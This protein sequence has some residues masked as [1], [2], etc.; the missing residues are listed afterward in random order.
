M[1]LKKAKMAATDKDGLLAQLL[2]DK[3][4][5]SAAEIQGALEE[6]L[7][8]GEGLL[9]ALVR[10]GLITYK[11]LS[12]LI[13]E[14]REALKPKH[15]STAADKASEEDSARATA[16]LDR[17]FDEKKISDERLGE[18]LSE[19]GRLSPDDLHRAKQEQAS[20]GHPLWRTLVNMRLISPQDL[21]TIMKSRFEGGLIYSQDKI[22]EKFLRE[23]GLI[24]EEELGRLLRDKGRWGKSLVRLALEKGLAKKP[25]LARALEENLKAQF[26]KLSPEIIDRS[27]LGLLP[28]SFVREQKVIPLS[29]EDKELRLAMVNP[30]NLSLIDSIGLMTGHKIR[31]LVALEDEI[32]SCIDSIFGFKKGWG[33]K[34]RTEA[35]EEKSAPLAPAAVFEITDIT[36]VVQIVNS[37]IE[38]AVNARATD[39]HIEPQ[40]PDM[41]VRYRIDGML[42]DIMTIPKPLQLPTISRVKILAEMDITERRMPQDGHFSHVVG[43]KEFNMR[44]ATMPTKV[45][46]KVVI[47]LLTESSVLTGLKQLGLEDDDLELFKKLIAKLH[48]LILVTGPIGSGKTTTLYAALNELN[49]LTN[50]I[51]TIE[52]P[53]EYRLAG[54]NQVEVEYKTGLTFASGL[55]SILRQDPDIIMV[56]EIRDTETA[57]VA[58]RAALTGQQVF[59]SLHTSDTPSAITT[60]YNLGIQPYLIASSLNSIVAQRLVRKICPF[61]KRSYAPPKGLLRELDLL[62]DSRLDRFYFG[63]GCDQCFHT[64]YL[65]R[66]GI[67]EMLSV[68]ERV[69]RLIIEQATEKEIK[70]AAMAEGMK[71]LKD[72]GVKKILSGITTPEEVMREIFL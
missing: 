17:S 4:L 62:G 23:K 25:D 72:G 24:G 69:K 60:I 57:K 56:G 45:G 15:G 64:G 14:S 43:S 68:T 71:P 66:T 55:R 11:D 33:A 67:F 58:V 70:E 47:R 12:E 27:I 8:T 26:V 32:E 41:R 9:A 63:E 44:V 52:D 34:R 49:I 21:M 36:S 54:I 65:G 5:L 50:N 10:K 37:I 42:Y 22:A 51:I 53:I 16:E 30:Q 20:T 13:L 6:A 59:S 40:I 31:P 38:G 48:G 19:L 35:S 1:L 7:S 29:V 18:A 3:G 28:E 39:I 2:M 46:E 61:C